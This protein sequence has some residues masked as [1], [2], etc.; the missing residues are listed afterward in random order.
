MISM[1]TPLHSP[2]RKAKASSISRDRSHCTLSFS[3]P[4]CSPY[5]PIMFSSKKA[6]TVEGDEGLEMLELPLGLRQKEP[7][8][9]PRSNPEAL[10]IEQQLAAMAK[11]D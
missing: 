6:T 9:R 7:G 4:L 5:V 2:L 11:F 1:M 10:A 3:N 8:E